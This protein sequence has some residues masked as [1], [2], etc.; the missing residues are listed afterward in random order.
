MEQVMIFK[1]LDTTRYPRTIRH[2]LQTLLFVLIRV[3]LFRWSA[4]G[5]YQFFGPW[6]PGF[7]LFFK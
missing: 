2:E 5:P 6:I 3:Q 7:D 1:G 4:I